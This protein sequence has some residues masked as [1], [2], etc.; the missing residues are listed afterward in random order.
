M[1]R[2]DNQWR[3]N[4]SGPLEV[5]EGTLAISQKGNRDFSPTNAEN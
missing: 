3:K 2:Y 5:L 1:L 4:L